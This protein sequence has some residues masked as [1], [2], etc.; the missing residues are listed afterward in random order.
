[1]DVQ[2]VSKE[3]DEIYERTRCQQMPNLRRKERGSYRGMKR[4]PESNESWGVVR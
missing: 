3:V 2:C 4:L 1:V